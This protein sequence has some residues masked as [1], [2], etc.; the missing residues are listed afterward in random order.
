MPP[1]A[2]SDGSPDGVRSRIPW[3]KKRSRHPAIDD[4]AAR[5]PLGHQPP[6]PLRLLAQAR[7]VAQSDRDLLRHH[8]P[9]MPARRQLHLGGRPRVPAPR[10]HRLLQHDHGP[11]LQLDL[12][13]EA[14]REETPPPVRPAP[15]PCQ[16]ARPTRTTKPYPL[17][18]RRFRVLAL[19]KL[20]GK[21]NPSRR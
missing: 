7:L 16:D 18:K 15:P 9:E 14:P 20:G 17:M 11:P 5:V 19:G 3:G 4:D 1:R 6:D 10:V 12:Y 21:R 2:W 13:R 8:P